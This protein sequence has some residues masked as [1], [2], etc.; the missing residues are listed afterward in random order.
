MEPDPNSE[1]LD[2]GELDPEQWN[3]YARAQGWSD[4]LPLAIP[5]EAAVE[6]FVATCLGDNEP[7]PPMSPRRLIPTLPVLAANA[8]MAGCRAEYF[9]VVLAAV[10]AVLTTEYNLHGTL[11][12]THPCAP[13]LLLNGPLRQSLEVN[14]SA[15]CFGQGWQANATIG[16]AL[17]LILLN[18]GGARPGVM[19]RSTQGSPAK[20]SFRYCSCFSTSASM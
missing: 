10:R 7:L 13:M 19:D 8:V 11:A 18:L 9:P 6:R 4:G 17:Q 5:T 16:R 20:Y 1:I 14:C 3:D 15:N 12:T 2:L